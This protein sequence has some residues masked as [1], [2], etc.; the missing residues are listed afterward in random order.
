MTGLL[1]PFLLLGGFG[2]LF[3]T[4]L[5][6]A[7]KKLAVQKDEKVEALRDCLPGANCGGC[8]YPGCDSYA[9]AVVGGAAAVDLCTPGGQKTVDAIADVLGIEHGGEMGK[10]VA[11]IVCRGS[12][13]NVQI[14]FDYSDE[15][16]C[17]VAA[18][19][20]EGDK[21]CRY[22]CVGYGDCV[23]VCPFGALS[24]S[25]D[26]LVIV[27]EDKCTGCGRCV[28]EC[29][30]NVIR[31]EPHYK[32]QVKCRALEKGKIVLNNCM[33][34]CIGCGKC[35]K[36]CKFDAIIMNDNLP[37]IDREKCV[38]CL[39]CAR[40]CP[41]GAMQADFDRQ[42]KAFIDEELCIGCTIC[43]R[44]CKFDA[45]SGELKEKHVVDTDKCTGCGLCVGKCPK[46]AIALSQ[47]EM[48]E[49]SEGSS[50]AR[51]V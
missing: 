5:A 33:A 23:H 31:I 1:Y 43:K 16:S 37:T 32:V 4:G 28:R 38:G 48:A 12:C 3:G 26:R 46:K 27:D 20:S 36:S 50:I 42:E 47:M 11:N 35:A 17:R 40:N 13:A 9:A 22:A 15:K 44:H 6:L 8:G 7:S 14:R 30:K 24:M 49:E 19:T 41:T 18:M 45:I 34:G 10:K 2:L 25:D 21:A 39:E 29:P 51:A